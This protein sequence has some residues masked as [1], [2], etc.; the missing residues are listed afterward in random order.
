M[1]STVRQLAVVVPALNEPPS[2]QVFNAAVACLQGEDVLAAVV[3]DLE[4]ARH[5][6]LARRPASHLLLRPKRR[7]DRHLPHGVSAEKVRT[8]SGFGIH[9]SAASFWTRVAEQARRD[10]HLCVFQDPTDRVYSRH[11]CGWSAP[12]QHSAWASRSPG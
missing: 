10:D 12:L 11:E 7:Q 2:R 1:R 6:P 5:D 8:C 9:P 3:A 4:D